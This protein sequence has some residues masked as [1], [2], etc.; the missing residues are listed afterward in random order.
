[1]NRDFWRTT[2]WLVI[3]NLTVTAAVV[4]FVLPSG[5]IM[6][7]AT[8]LALVLRHFT[9][10]DTAVAVMIVNLLFLLIGTLAIGKRF[11]FA[12]VFSS[13]AYPV[14]LAASRALP[15]ENLVVQDPLLC[16]IA[17]GAGL[18]AGCGLA[19]R[20]G[21]STGGT[22]G[23]ALA[24]NKWTHVD[25]ATL[26]AVIDVIILMLQMPFTDFEHILYG[27]VFTVMTSMVLNRVLLTGSAQLQLFVVSS[28][29]EEIR[30]CLL[31]V[32]NLGAT[33]VHIR[34]GIARRETEGIIT[35]IHP[36]SLY[37]VTEAIQRIDPE[38]FVTVI[39]AREVRG[40]GFTTQRHVYTE[41][42]EKDV[43]TQ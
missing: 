9:H 6:G 23:L 43:S 25:I 5:L 11:F 40:Q 19:V 4:L 20:I 14:L 42:E 1:M 10:M 27:V 12:S 3:A 17:G 8:G 37:A 15:L 2:A 30:K 34:T 32:L 31:Y 29:Q 13:V 7:G 28:R 33:M 41:P 35:V 26:A 24:V 38:A 21:V 36:R 22:D 16:A 39:Q 18:G